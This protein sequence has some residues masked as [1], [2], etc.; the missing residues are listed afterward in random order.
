MLVSKDAT[1]WI[2]IEDGA[3]CPQSPSKDLFFF[4]GRPVLTRYTSISSETAYPEVSKSIA[5]RQQLNLWKSLAGE[6]Q[7]RKG[8]R[9]WRRS[10]LISRRIKCDMVGA[11]SQEHSKNREKAGFHD[12]NI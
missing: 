9:D 2:I 7:W 11:R 5:G 10:Q 4:N 6:V 8:I 1:N 12:F 3:S